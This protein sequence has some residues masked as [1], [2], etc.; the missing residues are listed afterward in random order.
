MRYEL[1]DEEWAAGWRPWRGCPDDRH[2]YCP[3]ASARC[4]HHSE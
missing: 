3:R 4:L 1:A 2:V